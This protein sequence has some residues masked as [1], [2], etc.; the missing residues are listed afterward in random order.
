MSFPFSTQLEALPGAQ[1]TS[2]IHNLIFAA[3]LGESALGASHVAV[4]GERPGRSQREGSVSKRPLAFFGR[5]SLGEGGDGKR[6]LGPLGCAVLRESD[7]Q[8][9]ATSHGTGERE[10]E[11]AEDYLAVLQLKMLGSEKRCRFVIK[12]H[13][14]L[15][16]HQNIPLR[17]SFCAVQGVRPNLHVTRTHLGNFGTPG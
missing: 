6:A 4:V 7:V 9:R 8:V 13:I 11:P 2:N 15:C 12:L 5:T 17:L 10:R 3:A 16:R 14:V 1:G